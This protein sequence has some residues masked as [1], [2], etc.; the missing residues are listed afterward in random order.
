MGVGGVII[1][2]ITL[3][4]GVEVSY[5]A[6]AYPNFEGIRGISTIIS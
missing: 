4:A 5:L 1:G 2:L 6:F 3:V